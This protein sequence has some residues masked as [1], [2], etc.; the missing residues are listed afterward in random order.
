MNDVSQKGVSG[1]AVVQ[2]LP[3][4]LGSWI[5]KED[6]THDRPWLNLEHSAGQPA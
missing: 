4:F 5:I 2:Y 3:P 1:A 6:E